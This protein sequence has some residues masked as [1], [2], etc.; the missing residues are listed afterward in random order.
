MGSSLPPGVL[1]HLPFSLCIGSRGSPPL[2]PL[3]GWQSC[4]ILL[5]LSP[6][7]VCPCG[8]GLA[9]SSF[10]PLPPCLFAKVRLGLSC[11]RPLLLLLAP[12]SARLALVVLIVV[13]SW[14]FCGVSTVSDGG[15]F[16]PCPSLPCRSPCLPAVVVLEMVPDCIPWGPSKDVTGHGSLSMLGPRLDLS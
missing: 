6:V 7:T 10:R 13:G 11:L 9:H 2:T 5:C 12:L 15:T 4:W 14:P 8:R 3:S 1:R 16:K